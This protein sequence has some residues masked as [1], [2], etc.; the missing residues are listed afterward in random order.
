MSQSFFHI[1]KFV[2]ATG[3]RDSF[4]DLMKSYE[5]HAKQNGLDH[6]H[7]VEDETAPGTFMHVTLWASRDHWVQ[8]EK[9]ADHQQ[10]HTARNALLAEPMQHDFVAGGTVY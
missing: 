6:A 4:I 2:V 3:Q 1:G 8:V 7:L 9:S 10:M 5:S